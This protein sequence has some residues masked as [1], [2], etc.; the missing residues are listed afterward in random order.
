M[1]KSF[2]PSLNGERDAVGYGERD[3]KFVGV[4][5]GTLVGEEDGTF[6]GTA[7][8]EPVGVPLGTYLL[9]IEHPRNEAKAKAASRRPSRHHNRPTPLRTPLG[10]HEYVQ[11]FSHHA[12]VS[13]Y[14]EA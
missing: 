6:E 9:K 11:S 1:N 10:S 7:V 3:G 14:A 5:L 4:E 8:G 2:Q 12:T 13:S